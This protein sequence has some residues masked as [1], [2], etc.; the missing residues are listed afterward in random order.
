MGRQLGNGH[1]QKARTRS[2]SQGNPRRAIFSFHR[3]VVQRREQQLPTL[4]VAGSSPAIPA[5]HHLRVNVHANLITAQREHQKNA[6]HPGGNDVC[7]DKARCEL[8][9]PPPGRRRAARGGLGDVAQMGERP[10]CKREAR[11]SNPLISTCPHIGVWRSW[12]ARMLWEHEAAGS[13]PATPTA[14][15]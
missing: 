4:R 15:P 1:D 8:L 12:L 2:R 3:D 9:S 14:G 13:N 11:G 5:E 6:D 7:P 10:P